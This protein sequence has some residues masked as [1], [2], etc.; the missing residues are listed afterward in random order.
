LKIDKYVK[1]LSKRLDSRFPSPDIGNGNNE[2]EEERIVKDDDY[3][4]ERNLEPPRFAYYEAARR[5]I[6][7][8]INYTSS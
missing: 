1:D 5:I 6:A 8:H 3:Y 7:A 4:L 2:E